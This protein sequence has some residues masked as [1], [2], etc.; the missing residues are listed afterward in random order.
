MKGFIFG[1]VFG[2]VWSNVGFGG[3]AKMLDQGLTSLQ[4]YSKAAA[5]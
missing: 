4:T 5:R 2:V 3:M 1:V